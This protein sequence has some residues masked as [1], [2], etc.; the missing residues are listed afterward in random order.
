MACG[1]HRAVQ[2]GSP[3]AAQRNTGRPRCHDPSR[4]PLHSIQATLAVPARSG[5]RPLYG[6]GLTGLHLVL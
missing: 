4:I 2:Q 1:P 6:G 5:N 3:Y